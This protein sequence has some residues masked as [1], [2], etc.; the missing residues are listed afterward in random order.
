MTFSSAPRPYRKSIF[1]QWA[2]WVNGVSEERKALGH[3]RKVFSGSGA[4]SRFGKKEDDE[5]D[6]PRT[7]RAKALRHSTNKQSHLMESGKLLFDYP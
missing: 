1:N 3:V 6:E 5:G 2:L 4:S 7:A